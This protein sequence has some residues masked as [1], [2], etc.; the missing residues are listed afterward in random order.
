M[1]KK[2]AAAA[3]LAGVLMLAIL[4]TGIF[5]VVKMGNLTKDV[6]AMQKEVKAQG[7]VSEDLN[8]F[9]DTLKDIQSQTSKTNKTI[10][11]IIK[12][13][14]EVTGYELPEDGE[15]NWEDLFGLF[16]GAHEIWDDTE[17]V[18]AYHTGDASKLTDE[19]DIFVLE[20]VKKVI[21]EVITDDMTD[22]E[23]EKAIY[24]WQVCYTSYDNS[25]IG[26]IGE[27]DRY[28]HMPYGVLKYHQAICVG[29]ATT[30]KLFMSC[31]DIEC[32][33]IH[34]V[35]EGEH[36]WNLVKIGDSWYHVD[37]LFDGGSGTAPAY[38]FFNV[39]DEIKQE[40]GYPWSSEEFP[41]ANSYEYCYFVKEAVEVKNA[42]DIPAMIHNLIEKN[43]SNGSISICVD[44]KNLQ[45]AYY[46]LNTISES[47]NMGE[48]FMA[49]G[50]PYAI[51]DKNY[52]LFSYTEYY[53]DG[54]D[55]PGGDDF[56]QEEL[57]A[58]IEKYFTIVAPDP[59][60]DWDWD[61]DDIIYR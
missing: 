26:A 53:E 45:A 33:I 58:E 12:G 6:A 22:Y 9:E 51:N 36:A 28:S 15:F 48:G 21:D 24:D 34:S 18:K 55:F 50:G 30:F 37:V 39:T 31:L 27:A 59:D 32:K 13:V 29:Q 10:K 7:S 42:K 49:V 38:T 25:G 16:S 17:V 61:F 19:K 4:G 47:Y 54:P 35:V 46:V 23:K 11:N 43:P 14:S 60:D 44:E 8:D 56:N 1:S 52:L 41:A 5:S 57:D 2:K 20:T 3:G 40:S